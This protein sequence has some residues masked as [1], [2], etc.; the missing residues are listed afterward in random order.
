MNNEVELTANDIIDY[1][2][3][4]NS[5]IRATAI[6]FGCSKTLI[7]SRLKEYHGNK[8]EEIDKHLQLNRNNSKFKR[9][10]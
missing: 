6:H 5:S 4:T 10:K 9:I 3:E 1:M 2:L 7:W 8:K